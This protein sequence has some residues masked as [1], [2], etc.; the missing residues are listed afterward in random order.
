M[1]DKGITNM[2]NGMHLEEIRLSRQLAQ[3]MDQEIKGYGNI[4]PYAVQV[5]LDKLKDHYQKEIEE[6]VM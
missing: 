4:F 2:V 6:G 3:A 1:A 5:A